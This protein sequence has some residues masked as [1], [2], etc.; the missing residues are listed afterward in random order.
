MRTLDPRVKHALAY[1]FTKPPS[2]YVFADGSVSRG[3]SPEQL[4][5]LLASDETVLILV[6]GSNAAPDHLTRK[7]GAVSDA[8]PIA[9]LQGWVADVC[10]VY[11]SHF[12]R[13]GSVPATLMPMPGGRVRL[14][15]TL[16]ARSLLPIMHESESIG[17]NYGFF[18][19]PGVRFRTETQV[20]DKECHAYLSLHGYL[21][22]HGHPVGVAGL[23]YEGPPLT[24]MTEA[25]V[26]AVLHRSLAPNQPFDDFLLAIIED[27]RLRKDAIARM[28]ERFALPAE[29][30]ANWER[31][32]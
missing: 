8:P 31:L 1:P 15:C 4:N 24:R 5:A 29:W 27:E 25:E 12:A 32:E 20:L 18:R 11:S 21:A 22:L 23:P 28:K 3:I 13:Y 6:S 16:I 19:L 17:R 9:V 14:F 26:L 2:P 7:F 10:S 30:P